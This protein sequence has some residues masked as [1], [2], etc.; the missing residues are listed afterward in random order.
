MKISI[1][2]ISKD[3]IGQTLQPVQINLLSDCK[4]NIYLLTL[5][6]SSAFLYMLVDLIVFRRES[7]AGLLFMILFVGT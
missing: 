4:K 3:D 1:I 7:A 2:S 5:A 6:K